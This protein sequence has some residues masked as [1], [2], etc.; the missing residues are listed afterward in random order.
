[1]RARFSSPL[2]EP[3][4]MLRAVRADWPGMRPKA[5]RVTCVPPLIR[6]KKEAGREGGRE[7]EREREREREETEELDE[8]EK[9]TTKALRCF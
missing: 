6:R 8:R 5:R 9:G 1:M 3:A 2:G 7:K 4:I